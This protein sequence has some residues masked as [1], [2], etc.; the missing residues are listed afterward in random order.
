[1]SKSQVLNSYA[2]FIRIKGK[3]V[4]KKKNAV[5]KR[6]EIGNYCRYQSSNQSREGRDSKQSTE[7]QSEV[8]N[9]KAI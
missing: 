3:V 8:G 6:V 7:E 9:R 1:M 5:I 4:K 2:V